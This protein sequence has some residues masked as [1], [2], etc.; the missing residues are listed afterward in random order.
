MP[1]FLNGVN[2]ATMD[3]LSS[4]E[5]N[6]SLLDRSV[7]RVDDLLRQ[8]TEEFNNSIRALEKTLEEHLR[9]IRLLDKRATDLEKALR[10]A[11][12]ELNRTLDQIATEV[13]TSSGYLEEINQNLEKNDAAMVELNGQ[14]K[15]AA[16][17]E[18]KRRTQVSD[19]FET[20]IAQQRSSAE[21]LALAF[22]ELQS[23]FGDLLK[24]EEEST[25]LLEHSIHQ[26]SEALT[27]VQSQTQEELKQAI[28]AI[29]VFRQAKQERGW[30]E[31]NLFKQLLDVQESMRNHLSNMESTAARLSESTGQA[32]A[33]QLDRLVNRMKA[34]ALSLNAEAVKLMMRGEPNLAAALL[35]AAVKMDPESSIL[36]QNNILAHMRA[37]HLDLVAGLI[38]PRLEANPENPQILHLAGMLQLAL[39][40]P[41]QALEFLIHA[42][43][44]DHQNGEIF[45]TLGKARYA[46]GNIKDALA[47]WEMAVSMQPDL[48]GVD[49]L[50]KILMEEQHQP[51]DPL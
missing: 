25:R 2:L 48:A 8:R 19:K 38:N 51:K 49:P 14:F 16:E 13:E 10:D 26:M 24:T 15:Q 22:K 27:D 37:G 6:I 17:Q 31:N 9:L 33:H 21:A 29:E 18:N 34:Q 45:L 20:V 23:S 1:Y 44:M 39:G 50:V 41:Q 5:R 47:A 32:E 12:D 46:A 7:K 11:V 4:I 36:A 3:D 28:D 35:D 30:E 43:E 42:A 40:N